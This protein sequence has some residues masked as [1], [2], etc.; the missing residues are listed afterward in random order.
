MK[1]KF[2][3][4]FVILFIFLSLAPI[5]LAQFTPVN[6]A[7]GYPEW[8]I[9]VGEIL[10]YEIPFP[11]VS[12]TPAG[13]FDVI[14]VEVPWVILG[15]AGVILVTIVFTVASVF[16]FFKDFQRAKLVFSIAFVI[17]LFFGTRTVPMIMT[18][19]NAIGFSWF[20]IGMIVVFVLFWFVLY[21]IF[22]HPLIKEGAKS[23]KAISDWGSEWISGFEN[24]N[25]YDGISHQKEKKK[26]GQLN[27][28]YPEDEKLDQQELATIDSIKQTLE[29]LRER[30]SANKFNPEEINNLIRKFVSQL[31]GLENLYKKEIH[32]DEIE[33]KLLRGVKE[34]NRGQRLLNDP[35]QGK[36]HEIK[37]LDA[38]NY[39]GLE[40][41]IK[42]L[43]EKISAFE[44]WEKERDFNNQKQLESLRSQLKDEKKNEIPVDD[45]LKL[46]EKM[47]GL[48]KDFIEKANET[49]SLQHIYDFYYQCYGILADL[50]EKEEKDWNLTRKMGEATKQV[51]DKVFKEDSID[52]A[53]D[54]LAKEIRALYEEIKREI[55]K[56]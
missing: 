56:H 55:N 17:L 10:A 26:A 27:I 4:A 24:Y 39:P 20:I 37:K 29:E 23:S 48:T 16:P 7:R 50:K 21:R 49:G 54:Q 45:F 36:S 19:A 46:I 8:A 51:I 33:E 12:M 25:K 6:T 14:I 11:Y 28:A 2:R 41:K 47:K 1:S 32:L 13:D 52:T 35:L 22:S 43:Q 44:E 53:S 31:N 34:L 18:F 3:L 9:N 42:T 15:A 30:A 40:D 38:S 5:S